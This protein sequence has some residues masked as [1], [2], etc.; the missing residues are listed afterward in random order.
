M[1]AFR[2]GFLHGEQTGNPGGF[3]A[4]KLALANLVPSPWDM[5]PMETSAARCRQ[6]LTLSCVLKQHQMELA[7]GSGAERAAGEFKG[8]TY[9]AK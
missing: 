3:P 9:E 7:P 4:A 2:V 1:R 6:S 8:H 5:P